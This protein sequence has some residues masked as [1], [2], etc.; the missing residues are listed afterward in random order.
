MGLGVPSHSG[1]DLP[2]PTEQPLVN[3]LTRRK[4]RKS[5]SIGAGS[6]REPYGDPVGAFAREVAAVDHIPVD[7]LRRAIAQS[8]LE[9]WVCLSR[10][11]EGKNFGN[12]APL[13]DESPCDTRS[14]GAEQAVRI[15]TIILCAE[16]DVDPEL[17]AEIKGQRNVY[18]QPVARPVQRVIYNRT[19]DGQPEA[20]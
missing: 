6:H 20:L 3:Q 12:D 14:R 18:D 2:R 13:G 9:A 11:H 4:C 17:L 5:S 1:A 15:A 10:P 7:A 16:I 19:G 8:A